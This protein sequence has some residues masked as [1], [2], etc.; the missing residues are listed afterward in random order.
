[1]SDP[2][3][4]RRLV[5]QCEA[6]LPDGRSV[7]FQA[8]VDTGA[9]INVIRPDLIPVEFTNPLERPWNL[10][11]ANQQ[12]IQGGSREARVILYIKGTDVDTGKAQGLKI[13]TTFLLAEVGHLQAIV[14][15]EWL[16][17]HNFLVNGKRHGICYQGEHSND[18]VWIPG[19]KTIPDEGAVAIVNTSQP[20]SGANL[21]S[22]PQAS[23]ASPA[24]AGG[25]DHQSKPLTCDFPGAKTQ[26]ADWPE[27]D[28]PKPPG[29]SENSVDPGCPALTTEVSA[30]TLPQTKT[31][32]SATPGNAHKVD[33]DTATS[34][35]QEEGCVRCEKI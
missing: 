30:Q 13:P 23:H 17:N 28:I 32:Q 20:R 16:A 22:T 6:E 31:L 19:V 24:G 12:P 25:R 29:A 21:P 2:K 3:N 14:S 33:P 4:E 26:P 1:M 10:T 18:M 5:I 35:S 7:E 15:Y 27:G 8:L 11:A 34:S 9:E